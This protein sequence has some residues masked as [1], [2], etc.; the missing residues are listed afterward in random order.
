MDKKHQQAIEF[1]FRFIDVQ[2]QKYT[3]LT[4]LGIGPDAK[5][6]AALV[7]SQVTRLLDIL[8][9]YLSLT[10]PQQDDLIH[11]MQTMKFYL[12]CEYLRSRA[13][14]L[15]DDNRIHNNEY[16]RICDQQEEL[17]I[18]CNAIDGWTDIEPE[19]LTRVQQQCLHDSHAIAFRILALAA[20]LKEDPM[21]TDLGNDNHLGHGLIIMRRHA[22]PGGR[23]YNPIISSEITERL[24]YADAYLNTSSLTKSTLELDQM[25][26]KPCIDNDKVKLQRLRIH[27]N[28]LANE[29]PQHSLL[30]WGLFAAGAAVACTASVFAMQNSRFKL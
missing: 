21:R 11:L 1:L 5:M 18:L 2:I 7:R 14:W 29:N 20:T 27:Y 30:T 16:D 23:Y 19:K 25:T 22:Q 6:N 17:R 15:I 4:K 13:S 28:T 9:S 10:N 3:Q 12:G 8:E 24:S 26:S